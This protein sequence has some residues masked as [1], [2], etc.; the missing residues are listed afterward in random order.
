[1]AAA[2]LMPSTSFR[3]QAS[4]REQNA[5]STTHGTPSVT[6]AMRLYARESMSPSYVSR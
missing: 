1:M 2:Q 5:A 6:L 3:R 4:E